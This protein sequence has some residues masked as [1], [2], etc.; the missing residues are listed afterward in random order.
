MPKRGGGDRGWQVVAEVE[1]VAAEAE[2]VVEG[3]IMGMEVPPD[4]TPD[5]PPVMP[6]PCQCQLLW[7]LAH[8]LSG[9]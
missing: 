1:E 6:N 3:G 4:P 2:V 8:H 5:P 9:T 7:I